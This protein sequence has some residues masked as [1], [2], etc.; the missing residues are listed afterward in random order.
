MFPQ[1]I[2]GVPGLREQIVNPD[3]RAILKAGHYAV[4]RQSRRV[5][6]TPGGMMAV[7][8]QLGEMLVCNTSKMLD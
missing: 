6:L 2:N 7:L 4:D 1:V 3:S 5:S 8:R